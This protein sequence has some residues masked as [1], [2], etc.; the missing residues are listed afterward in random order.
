[1]LWLTVCVLLVLML[2]LACVSFVHVHISFS[3]LEHDDRLVVSI[4]GLYGLVRYRIVVPVIQFKNVSE[5][6]RV[7]RKVE[8]ESSASA[9]SK[10]ANKITAETIS[11]F[12]HYGKDIVK[13]TLD[14]LGWLRDVMKRVRCTEFRWDSHIGVGDAP[15][16]AITTGVV[17]GLKSSILSIIFSH[18]Q[19]EAKPYVSV[20]PLYNQTQFS[21]ELQCIAK[22]RLGYAIKAGWHL[23]MRVMKVKG[24]LRTWQNIL[25][26]A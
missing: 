22:I 6:I 9:D 16:T 21:T 14:L 1:M 25:F 26:K 12:Y 15:E 11:D 24:G 13:H 2:V 18:I 23:L 8:H 4:K 7:E 20:N 3:R 10:K 17:W 19:L 5:G